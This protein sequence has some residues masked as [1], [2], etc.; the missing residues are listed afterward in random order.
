MST[1][2]TTMTKS[3]VGVIYQVQGRDL[4]TIPGCF[5][6]G[7]KGVYA[8]YVRLRD[9]EIL[10]TE[11]RLPA[12]DTAYGTQDR[13]FLYLGTVYA[14]TRRSVAMRF[15]GELLGPQI[16]SDKNRSFDTD[17]TVSCVVEFLC[18]QGLNI[19]FDVLSNI[20]GCAEELRLAKEKQP[21]LQKVGEKSVRLYPDIKRKITAAMNLEEEIAAVGD[22]ALRRLR[23]W[24]ANAK[25]R[26]HP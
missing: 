24:V 18:R 7:I 11:Y 20:H 25:R 22:A 17:F 5:L 8:W 26:S 2:H 6:E 21:I 14:G 1:N 4:L 12:N 15:V 9:I 3:A 13:I 23:D 16:S 19:Y 10:G